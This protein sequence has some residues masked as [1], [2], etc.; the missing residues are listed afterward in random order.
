M[1]KGGVSPKYAIGLRCPMFDQ[2]N[3]VRSVA[4]FCNWNDDVLVCWC[5]LVLSDNYV[6]KLK[7]AW[8]RGTPSCLRDAS[9][10]SSWQ[11]ALVFLVSCRHPPLRRECTSQGIS[12]TCS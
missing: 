5:K 10:I 8:A 1:K 11:V 2:F 12:Q 7:L 3:H 6:M 9:S 4:C